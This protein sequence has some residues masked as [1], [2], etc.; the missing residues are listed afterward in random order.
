MHAVCVPTHGE[1]RRKREI[2]LTFKA[3]YRLYKNLRGRR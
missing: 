3:R 1:S 2:N